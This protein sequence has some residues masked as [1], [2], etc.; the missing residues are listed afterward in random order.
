VGQKKILE[1]QIKIEERIIKD[2]MK[3]YGNKI[4]LKKSPYLIVEIIRNYGQYFGSWAGTDCES[5][6][7]P[8]GVPPAPTPT[9]PAPGP[10]EMFDFRER[11]M[12]LTKDINSL[13][14]RIE[15]LEKMIKS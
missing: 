6:P 7:L 2:I 13:T 1:K 11:Y 4:D 5:R 15:K 3:K 14:K 9:P 12:I 8:G 10:A